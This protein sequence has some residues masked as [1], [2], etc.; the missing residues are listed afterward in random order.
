VFPH[1]L[2]LRSL[3]A[4]M[5]PAQ[6]RVLRR[7]F[8]GSHGA[9]QFSVLSYKPERRLVARLD[10]R[11]RATVI[12]VYRAGQSI[13]IQ[14]IAMQPDGVR[15]ARTVASH[16]RYPIVATEWIEG[17]DGTTAFSSGDRAAAIGEALARL[18]N[19]PERATWTR[20]S[21]DEGRQLRSV[22]AGLADLM[23]K[24]AARLNHLSGAIADALVR[25]APAAT[26]THGDFAA[27]Q[28]VFAPDGVAFTDLDAAAAADPGVDIGSFLADLDY[29]VVRGQLD[30]ESAARTADRFLDGYRS[31]R[32][33]P[34][35]LEIHH[36]AHL[37][38]VGPLPFR[39]RV[40]DWRQRTEVLLDRCQSVA[41]RA[42]SIRLA[43]NHPASSAPGAS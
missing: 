36:A 11:G 40:S 27:R 34:R 18:H 9:A 37:L 2:K 31:V 32:V 28:V 26:L 19:A 3:H 42:E 41:S 8:P 25:L 10:R 39:T 24:H 4:L 38:R 6:R 7:L 43:T 21:E 29:R 15:L 13:R 20:T 14:D 17:E 1:D 30:E 12:R 35:G 16:P 23:P 22:A 33:L 5:G